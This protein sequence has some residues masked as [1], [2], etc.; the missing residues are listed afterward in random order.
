MRLITKFFHRFQNKASSQTEYKFSSLDDSPRTDRSAR[1][2]GGSSRRIPEYVINLDE[3]AD[4]RWRPLLEE[5]RAMVLCTTELIRDELA[6]IL[7]PTQFALLTR[8]ANVLVAAMAAC[9]GVGYAD[10]LRAFASA[11]G[12][13]LGEVA[14]ANLMYEMSSACTAVVVDSDEGPVH[15]RTLDWDMPALADLLV[16]LAFEK[17]RRPFFLRIPFFLFC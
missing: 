11:L 8:C 17:A 5:N 9:G 3:P 6:A 14:F 13:S 7:G 2:R 16:D 12:L 1:S 15:G 4:R 10:D